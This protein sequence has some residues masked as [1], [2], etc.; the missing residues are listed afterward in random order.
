M[1]PLKYKPKVNTGDLR[2]RIDV[3]GNVKYEN[4]LGESSFK[5]GKVKTIWA[6]IIPQT[7]SLQ[8]QTGDT[9]LTNV[10][11]KIEVRYAAGKDITK[12]MQIFFEDNNQVVHRYEIKYTLNPFFRNETIEIFCQELMS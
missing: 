11:H 8:K 10:T 5:F 7:G 2:H 1:Q 3:Y 4:E 12:D 6:N 9:I